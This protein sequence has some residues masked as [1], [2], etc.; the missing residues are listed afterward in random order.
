MGDPV[1]FLF[2]MTECH[3]M[4]EEI[5][6]TP[7]D[8]PKNKSLLKRFQDP[9]NLG[10]GVVSLVLA[11]LSIYLAVRAEPN[12]EI[13]WAV[14]RQI[15]YNH[16]RAR[17][18]LTVLDD[19]GQK[20][21]SDIYA[22]EFTIWNSGNAR[23]DNVDGTTL[24]RRPL[25]LSFTKSDRVIEASIAG[26]RNDE[27]GDWRLQTTSTD[28]QMLWKHFDPKAIVKILVLH[29]LDRSD[30]IIRPDI[31]LAGGRIREIES[32]PSESALAI[33]AV[34]GFIALFAV[35]TLGGF[36][37][38]LLGSSLKTIKMFR[39]GVFVRWLG[40]PGRNY[41]FSVEFVGILVIANLVSLFVLLLLLGWT[42]PKVP[43]V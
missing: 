34:V 42:S 36:L 37:L 32:I 31:I 35:V 33:Y 20:I 8:R 3:E 24:I 26:A 22:S 43:Q 2:A 4:P 14:R 39:I 11:V 17:P 10:I 30:E 13:S 40:F 27:A 16:E 21:G 5:N 18:S 41:V 9:V 29:T 6:K 15:I 7:D 1:I 23:L 19:Q 12:Y 38:V 25:T 28:V